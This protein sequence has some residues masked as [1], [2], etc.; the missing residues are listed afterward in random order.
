MF[1]SLA[2]SI[3]QNNNEYSVIISDQEYSDIWQKVIEKMKGYKII[4]RNYEKGLIKYGNITFKISGINA[5]KYLKENQSIQ[6]QFEKIKPRI[7]KLSVKVEICRL[8][9]NGDWID[10]EE[11]SEYEKTLL[12]YITE[13]RNT[14]ITY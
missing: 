3:A 9:K 6:I 4:E 5:T 8:Q 11:T 2:D 13:Y 10:I 12:E 14:S 1:V 7:T